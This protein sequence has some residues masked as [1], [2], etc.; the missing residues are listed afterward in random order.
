MSFLLKIFGSRL[1]SA[2]EWRVR[3]EVDREREVIMALDDSLKAIAIQ[4]IDRIQTLE[5]V[6]RT[7]S[8]RVDELEQPKTNL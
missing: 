8:H 2:I 4:H 3:Q 5:D 1:D 7:L 6:I